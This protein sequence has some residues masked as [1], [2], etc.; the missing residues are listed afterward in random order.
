MGNPCFEL[1]VHVWGGRLGSLDHGGPP[2]HPTNLKKSI[3]S[4]SIHTFGLPISYF[5]VCGVLF[6]LVS[7]TSIM[8]YLTNPNNNLLLNFIDYSIDN[9]GGSPHIL[10]ST[11]IQLHVE[12]IVDLIDIYT[13]HQDP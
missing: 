3:R 1:R 4:A 10:A 2:F 9:I 5:R 8:I 6:P 11:D 13:R 7:L 12:A